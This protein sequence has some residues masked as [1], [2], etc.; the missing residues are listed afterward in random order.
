MRLGYEEELESKPAKMATFRHKWEETHVIT[1]RYLH[2]FF[3]V[4]NY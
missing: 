2:Q 3:F 1:Y 4:K